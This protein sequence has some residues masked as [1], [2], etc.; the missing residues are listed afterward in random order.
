MLDCAFRRLE[1]ETYNIGQHSR[2]SYS[3]IEFETNVIGICTS[4]SILSASYRDQKRHFLI[5][6]FC[7][8]DALLI[9]LPESGIAAITSFYR[10]YA[11]LYRLGEAELSFLSSS[12]DDDMPSL[13]ES[14][15]LDGSNEIVLRRL[16]RG[17]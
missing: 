10:F 13:S 12:I 11:C 3:P 17:D 6:H 7:T 4:K 14:S 1:R 16:K 9:D 8:G 5:W 15:L 2:V